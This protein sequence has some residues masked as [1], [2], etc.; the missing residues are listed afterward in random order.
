MWAGCQKYRSISEE[1]ALLRI[2]VSVAGYKC[3]VDPIACI[4]SLVKLLEISALEFQ[5]PVPLTVPGT[6]YY[7]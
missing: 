6:I 4:S 7:S 2:T 5:K 1:G 3:L